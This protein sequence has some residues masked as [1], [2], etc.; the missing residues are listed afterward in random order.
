MK[1]ARRRSRVSK[2]LLSQ[3]MVFIG[4]VAIVAI[5]IAV[6]LATVPYE[7]VPLA[8]FGYVADQGCWDLDTSGTNRINDGILGDLGQNSPYR[9]NLSY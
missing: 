9:D 2:K 6:V 5:I 1:R 3:N 7:G 4:I 8:K